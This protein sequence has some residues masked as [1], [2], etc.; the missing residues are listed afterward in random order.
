MTIFTPVSDAEIAL[1]LDQY[2]V[3]VVHAFHDTPSGVENSNLFL[4]TGKSGRT[5]G[6]VVTLF[7]R[8]TF[9]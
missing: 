3:G 9:E 8:L 7:E 1:W 5:H 4:T 6:Y 2:D